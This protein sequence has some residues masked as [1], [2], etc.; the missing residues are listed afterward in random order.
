MVHDYPDYCRG[1]NDLLGSVYLHTQLLKAQGYDLLTISYENFSIQ[2][3]LEK[4]ISY[5][6]QCMKDVL[7]KK[8]T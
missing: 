3:K 4:R 1:Q 5:L 2:D 7:K 8:S 6:E